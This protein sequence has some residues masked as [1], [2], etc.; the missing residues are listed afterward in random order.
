MKQ[1]E[2]MCVCLYGFIG[3]EGSQESHEST[4]I[5]P[6]FSTSMCPPDGQASALANELPEESYQF[7][8]LRA[9]V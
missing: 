6:D 7:Q 1:E 9:T 2:T 4:V 8:F 5:Y 3:P